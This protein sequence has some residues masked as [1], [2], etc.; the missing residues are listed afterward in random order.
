MQKLIIIFLLLFGLQ[1][2]G[3]SQWEAKNISTSFTL[4]CVDFL[5]DDIGFVTGGN[6][7]FKTEN[8]GETW[9]IS[10]TANSSVFYEDII[11]INSNNM[12]A[13]GKNVNSGQST[14]TKTSNGGAS[15]TEIATPNFSF[16]KSVF[17]S[18]PNIGYCSGGGGTILKSTDAGDHWQTLNSGTGTN[19]ESI[20]FVNDMVG[21]AVGGITGSAI[22]LKTQDGGA[23]WDKIN[24]GSNNNLQSVF[25]SNQETGYVVGW[26]GEIL[27]TE[28]CG[29]TWTS[30]TSVSMTGNLKIIFTDSN[31]GYIAGGAMSQSS[32]QKTSNGGN[33]WE[34]V[35]PQASHGLV[36]ID[37][38]SFHVGYAVGGNGTVFKT[39][40]GGASVS[41]NNT[42]SCNDFIVSPNPTIGVLKI[43]SMDNLIVVGLKIYDNNGRV[44]NEV[45]PN[46]SEVEIDL[47]DLDANAYYLEINTKEEKCIRK[48]VKI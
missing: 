5:N 8:G 48:I 2:T 20:Y 23:T 47:S 30:Q 36:S 12:I 33:S 7:V 44:M 31:T 45:S 32:I 14:I 34:D 15:W 9:S 1:I 24:T 26:N 17:F 13:V 6:R 21:I 19:L 43:Q 46:S 42:E 40:S 11:V 37:F 4:T 29:D 3:Y 35:S 18:S 22:M 16:L 25:F 10:Y 39:E 27:K 41:T 38:P 28:N